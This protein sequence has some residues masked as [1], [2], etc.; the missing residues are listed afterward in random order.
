[1]MFL[2]HSKIAKL[3]RI[4]ATGQCFCIGETTAKSIPEQPK[5]LVVLENPSIKTL[6]AKAIQLLKKHQHA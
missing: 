2:K 1:M 4:F 6:V 5:E 3:I